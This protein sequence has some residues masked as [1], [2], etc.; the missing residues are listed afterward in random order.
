MSLLKFSLADKDFDMV[1]TV[2]MYHKNFDTVFHWNIEI[3]CSLDL[4]NHF[5]ISN[6][7]TGNHII[8]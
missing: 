6:L 2:D 4:S 3:P 8:I 5:N 7:D 1:F